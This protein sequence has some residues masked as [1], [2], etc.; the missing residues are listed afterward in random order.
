MTTNEKEE[1]EMRKQ[2]K[3][4]FP[5]SVSTSEMKTLA[6]TQ[7]KRMNQINQEKL[8]FSQELQELGYMCVFIVPTD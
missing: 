3:L 7:V 6:T 2:H 8:G 4:T 1:A 5:I